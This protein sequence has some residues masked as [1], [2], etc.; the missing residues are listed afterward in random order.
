MTS[1]EEFE[2]FVTDEGHYPEA[3]ERDGDG[4]KYITTQLWWQAWQAARATDP[5]WHDKPT[6]P[7]LW[8][9]G[10]TGRTIRFNA[11]DIDQLLDGQGRWY[12]PIPEIKT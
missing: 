5:A 3:A 4:Y 9:F 12:G 10:E 11:C 2:V 6:G 1:R 7:G 8:V